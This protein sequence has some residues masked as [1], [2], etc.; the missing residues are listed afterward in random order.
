[1]RLFFVALAVVGASA[2]LPGPVDHEAEAV[3][4]GYPVPFIVQEIGLYEVFGQDGVPPA[5]DWH[6]PLSPW[7]NAVAFRPLAFALDVAAVLAVLAV[8]AR[9][10]GRRAT[11][12]R[13][14]PPL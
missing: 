11:T 2:L 10:V 3:R 1:M 12:A 6:G 9:L 8:A 14:N 4:L 5:P 7:E 13:Q